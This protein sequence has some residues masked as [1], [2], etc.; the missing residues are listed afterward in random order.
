VWALAAASVY[1]VTVEQVNHLVEQ[2]LHQSKRAVV[3]LAE[4]VRLHTPLLER[5]EWAAAAGQLRECR[6]DS[7]RVSWHPELGDNRDLPRMCESNQIPDVVLDVEG[8]TTRN[9]TAPLP[10]TAQW[11]RVPD[12]ADRRQVL[13]LIALNPPALAIGQVEMKDIQLVPT[14]I[15]N[16]R[17]DTR[18][19]MEVATDIEPKASPLKAGPVPDRYTWRRRRDADRRIRD[20]LVG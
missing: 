18:H 13:E 20:D 4:H 7:P 16:R 2:T 19:W 6:K 5:T 1:R 9:T 17:L 11:G 3:T 15:V 12:R 8:G 14:H 10:V